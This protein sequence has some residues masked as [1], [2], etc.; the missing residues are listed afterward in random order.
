VYG[1]SVAGALLVVAALAPTM[2]RTLERADNVRFVYG[3]KAP[4][5]GLAVRLLG[6]IEASQ[7]T[8]AAHATSP[9]QGPQ[10][11]GVDWR[12]RD[13]VLITVD[14]LRADHLGSYGYG[15]PITPNLDALARESARFTWAYAA[16]PHTSYSVSSLMTGKYMRPLLLQGVGADSDTF[17]HLMRLY[18]YRTAAF[19]PP[20]VFFIDTERFAGMRDRGLDFEYRR[21]ELSDADQR[22][23]QIETYLGKVRPERRIFLWVHLFEPHEPYVKHPEHDLGDHDVDRY[24]SEI[25]SADQGIGRIIRAVRAR[26]PQAIILFT[27]DH[28]EEF[29]DHGGRYHGTTV[30][31]E[32]VRVPL[33]ISAPGLISPREINVPVQTID[34]LPTTLGALQIPRSAR[35]RGRDLGP[36]LGPKAPEADQGFAFSETDESTML[37]EGSLRL[38]CL[39]KIGACKL[40]DVATDPGETKDISSANFE[41]FGALRARLKEVTDATNWQ[42]S[43]PRGEPGLTPSVGGSPATRT[44]RSMWRLSSTMWRCR[45]AG[46]PRRSC[47]S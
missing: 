38:V 23:D 45:I 37:A 17:A 5:N 30:Y 6:A 42:G 44:L 46:K 21:A 18:G 41:R 16:T 9:D 3:E 15:R 11:E 22:A 43:A 1:A 32:Q 47:S 2:A 14:A 7:E 36:W 29:G 31:E 33:L 12:G 40:F 19:Y 13:L 4:L 28:G 39:R 25:A 8:A 10:G 27:A 24:D 34:L 35:I 26:R 20:A